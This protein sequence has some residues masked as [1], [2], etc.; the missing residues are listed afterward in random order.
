METVLSGQL[1]NSNKSKIIETPRGDVPVEQFAKWQGCIGWAM[2]N[3]SVE[4]EAHNLQ[5]VS[6]PL[7][8]AGPRNGR[9]DTYPIPLFSKPGSYELDIRGIGLPIIIPCYDFDAEVFPDHVV[10]SRSAKAAK[11][12]ILGKVDREPTLIEVEIPTDYTGFATVIKIQRSCIT[13]GTYDIP[14]YGGLFGKV[15][16]NLKRPNRFSD[17]IQFLTSGGMYGLE[18]TIRRRSTKMLDNICIFFQDHE[19]LPILTAPKLTPLSRKDILEMRE[20]LSL[21]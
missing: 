13:S 2:D 6:N 1:A 9:P 11:I 8:D 18:S 7:A 3:F 12:D 19:V 16:R 4:A 10:F 15:V 17:H 14:Q 21:I 5:F 20:N